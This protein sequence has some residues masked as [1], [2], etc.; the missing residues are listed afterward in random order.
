MLFLNNH[1]ERSCVPLSCSTLVERMVRTL[2]TNELRRI[3][4]VSQKQNKSVHWHTA[5]IIVKQLLSIRE[6]IDVVRKIIADCKTQD[7]E[8]ELELL[9]FATRVNIIA[10]YAFIDLPKDIDELYY[11]VYA[12]DLY[13]VVCSVANKEQVNSIKNAISMIIG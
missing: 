9:D 10:Y 7:G 5:T 12:S 6:F 3:T 11:V 4:G 2:S 13:D 1:K 8:V